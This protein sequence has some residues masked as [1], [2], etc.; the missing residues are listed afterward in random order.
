MYSDPVATRLAGTKAERGPLFGS[1]LWKDSHEAARPEDWLETYV[2]EVVK[3]LKK[4]GM[5]AVDPVPGK[6]PARSFTI[7]AN[8]VLRIAQS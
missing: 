6:T 3:Q 5:I 2:N 1:A 7:V 4:D 8:P